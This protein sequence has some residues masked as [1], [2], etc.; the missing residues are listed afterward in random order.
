MLC[1]FNT[2]RTCGISAGGPCCNNLDGPEPE[3]AAPLVTRGARLHGQWATRGRWR[4]TV[5]AR[6]DAIREGSPW[7]RR[8]P[9]GE[10]SAA[11]VRRVGLVVE[12]L[13]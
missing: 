10:A 12:A 8:R 5:E 7:E 9:P 13:A 6:H 3:H 11:S 2:E 1:N 4:G